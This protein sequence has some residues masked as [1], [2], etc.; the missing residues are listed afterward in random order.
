MY[1]SFCNLQFQT[2]KNGLNEQFTEKTTAPNE[3]WFL[4]LYICIGRGW[5]P[6]HPIVPPLLLEAD[7]LM[8]GGKPPRDYKQSL[9]PYNKFYNNS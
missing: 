4:Y 3:P 6:R 7:N 9:R 1:H 2:Q 5:R 8:E